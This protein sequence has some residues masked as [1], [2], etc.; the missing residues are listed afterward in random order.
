MIDKA[1]EVVA[2]AKGKMDEAVKYLDES[3]KNY[4]AGKAN[5]SVF[6][7]VM[8]DYY[9][10]MTPLPQMSSIST[11]DA[12]TIIV[13]PWD[14]GQ[15]K[16]IEKAIIDANLGYTPSNNGEQIRIQ[17]PSLTEE[18]R[19]E[20]VKKSHTDGE[21][22]KVSIRNTRRDAIEALKKMIKDGLPEDAEKD[23]ED[24]VQKATDS[25]SK[26]IDELL[27]VKEKE[28]MTV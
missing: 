5:P 9:G 25:F 3:L 1:Q 8:V 2:S 21:S 15:L 12:K 24:Q 11:P 19:R 14:K 20:L 18:R 7:Q 16:I 10:T 6:N 4:R 22:A 27:A 23:F 26:K 28:I 17:V 13:Q